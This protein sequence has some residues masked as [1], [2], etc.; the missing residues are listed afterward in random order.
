MRIREIFPLM[1]TGMQGKLM[2]NYRPQVAHHP[3][4]QA[5]GSKQCY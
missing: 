5:L 3:I 2:L 1:N 4:I